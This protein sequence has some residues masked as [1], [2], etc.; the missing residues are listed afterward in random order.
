MTQPRSGQ[1]SPG[2][3]SQVA[4][5]AVSATTPT[6]ADGSSD[7]LLREYYAL[8]DV[9]RDFDRNL[10]TVKGW[11]ATV[12]LAGLAAAFQAKNSAAFLIACVS[13]VAF[14]A[15]EAAMKRHQMQYYPRMREIEAVRF[16]QSEWLTST[17]QIDWSWSHAPEFLRNSGLIQEPRREPRAIDHYSGGVWRAWIFWLPPHVSMPHAISVVAG[18]VFFWAGVTGKL[19]L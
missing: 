12:S 8:L 10:L 11:G 3:S 9:V 16:R 13:G 17:P 1:P 15:I 6:S 2:Q 4:A 18:A 7:A 5:G 14:W 19:A